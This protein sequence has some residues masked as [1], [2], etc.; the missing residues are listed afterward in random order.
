[1]LTG[2]LLLV[3]AG[4]SSPTLSG[5]TRRSVPSVGPMV[6]VPSV[7]AIGSDYRSDSS[8]CPGEA[9]LL[10][11]LCAYSDSEKCCQVW[12]S[13]Y[14]TLWRLAELEPWW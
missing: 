8:V 9:L 14:V 7:Q 5:F 12:V 1:M 6:P 2:W 11:E 10:N 13:G 4:L 3:V